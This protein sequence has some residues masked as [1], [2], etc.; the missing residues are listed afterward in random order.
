FLGKLLMVET[1]AWVPRTQPRPSSLRRPCTR[2]TRLRLRGDVYWRGL[3]KRHRI[4]FQ[5][6]RRCH[7]RNPGVRLTRP[8]LPRHH[9]SLAAFAENHRPGRTLGP[10]VHFPA[11][12][13]REPDHDLT[14]PS[15]FWGRGLGLRGYRSAGSLLPLEAL[16]SFAKLPFQPGKTIFSR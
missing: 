2:R 8:A 9:R 5:R 14:L 13:T 15:P 6:R 10:P 3:I 1:E 7:D 12:F 11:V 16:D 4:K